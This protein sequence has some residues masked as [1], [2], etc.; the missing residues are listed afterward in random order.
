[1]IEQH[2]ITNIEEVPALVGAFA[3]AL[4]WT[5]T[6]PGANTVTLR[7]P[8]D[9]V[10]WTLR[11]NADTLQ[12]LSLGEDSNSIGY[13][14]INPDLPDNDMAIMAQPVLRVGGANVTQTPTTV[15]LIGA[16]DPSPY[17]HIAVAFGENLFRHMYVGIM[18]KLGNYLR[19]N[20]IAATK[21]PSLTA[22]TTLSYDDITNMKYL[23]QGGNN[24]M[25]ES[26]SG[27]VFVEHADN[28]VP[29][30]RFYNGAFQTII[31]A[32][33]EGV[34]G[35]FGDAIN[36]GYL[37]R[38]MSPFAALSILAPVNLYVTQ[39]ISGD[40]TFVPIGRVPGIRMVNMSQLE[41]AQEIVVGGMRWIVFPSHSR[42]IEKTMTA[43]GSGSRARDFESSYWVG[44]AVAIAEEDSN[45]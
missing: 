29:W 31:G 27:G 30:R 10:T 20:V 32:N 25:A 42:R 13:T 16:N 7:A 1:M 17:I 5:S 12:I 26:L 41:P 4:G 39:P 24:A 40:R 21:G 33:P 34:I 37:A 8:G 9:V 15:Y 45:S 3:T 18:E 14:D 43:E 36:D 19:G 44:Y 23:F 38:A 35:G 2:S 28:A 6:T 11:E 22:N